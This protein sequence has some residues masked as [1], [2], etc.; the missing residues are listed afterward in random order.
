M[1]TPRRV[2]GRASK[3]VQAAKVDDTIYL[4][5]E[6]LTASEQDDDVIGGTLNDDI[7]MA[8]MD[9]EGRMVPMP[10]KGYGHPRKRPQ[11]AKNRGKAR[12]RPAK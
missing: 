8:M 3:K 10:V 6:E 1:P 4:S 7:E 11:S 5:D 9:T 12:S 2:K